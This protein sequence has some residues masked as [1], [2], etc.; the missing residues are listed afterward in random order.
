MT[1]LQTFI[2]A[3]KSPCGWAGAILLGAVLVAPTIPGPTDYEHEWT[4]AELM[5]E[6]QRTEAMSKER[7]AAE[8]R[9]CTSLRGP[10]SE[11]RYTPDGDAVCTTR[12]G[13][14]KLVLL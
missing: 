13:F 9:L 10:N 1:R 8:Q 2:Q 3:L 11:V 6:I 7:M 5:L 14:R 12:Q 4:D